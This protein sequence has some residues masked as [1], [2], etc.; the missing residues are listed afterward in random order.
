MSESSRR[1]KVITC[2]IPVRITNRNIKPRYNSKQ[3]NFNNLKKVKTIPL[4]GFRTKNF[5][6]GPSALLASTTSLL[7]KIDVV[8]CVVHEENPDPVCITETWLHAS[9]I[10]EHLFIPGYNVMFKN[11]ASQIHGCVCIYI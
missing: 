1:P 5:E 6:F 8:R 10:N 2:Q 3:A 7:P 11:C 9:T 4:I